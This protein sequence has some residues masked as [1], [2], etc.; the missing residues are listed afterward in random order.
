[1]EGLHWP[2]AEISTEAAE[3]EN[4]LFPEGPEYAEIEGMFLTNINGFARKY[5]LHHRGL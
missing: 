2:Y 1:M 4:S 3:A 5:L